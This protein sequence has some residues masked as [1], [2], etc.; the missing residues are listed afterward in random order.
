M[1][2]LRTHDVSNLVFRTDVETLGYYRGE[3]DLC[4][5]CY[6]YQKKVDFLVRHPTELVTIYTESVTQGRRK[7]SAFPQTVR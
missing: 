2:L 3:S 1:K 5:L 6:R 4:G 7:I